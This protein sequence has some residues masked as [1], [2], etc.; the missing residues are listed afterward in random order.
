MITQALQAPAKHL[1]AVLANGNP[2][3]TSNAQGFSL[4][5][6]AVVAA[7]ISLAEGAN[8]HGEG[9]INMWGRPGERAT[10]RL[11]CRSSSPAKVPSALALDPPRRT[12]P[13][14]GE[15]HLTFLL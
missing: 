13:C 15:N 8:P 6:L 12:S 4:C 9:Q 10:V 2:A 14:E 3:T 5:L 11:G 1:L 7:L